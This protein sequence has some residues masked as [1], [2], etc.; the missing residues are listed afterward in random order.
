MRLKRFLETNRHLVA[1]SARKSSSELQKDNL[2]FTQKKGGPD[3]SLKSVY[4]AFGKFAPDDD[5]QQQNIS[6][7]STA[8]SESSALPDV[9]GILYNQRQELDSLQI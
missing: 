6:H 3:E 9:D 8:T 7:Q 2:F 4:D 1:F 5:S